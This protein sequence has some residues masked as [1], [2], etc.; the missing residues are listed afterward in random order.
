MESSANLVV[1]SFDHES[2][3]RHT[4]LLSLPTFYQPAGVQP[5]P[6]P[7]GSTWSVAIPTPAV[8]KHTI[9][10]RSTQGFST[11]AAVSTNFT[12]KR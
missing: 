8:R 7:T 3:Q 12:V 6:T 9:Y 1:S 4:Y 10:A 2:D 11:S 5:P